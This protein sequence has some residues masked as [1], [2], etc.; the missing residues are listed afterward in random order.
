M[1]P[2]SFSTREVMI[3]QTLIHIPGILLELT[4]EEPDSMKEHLSGHHRF[5]SATM[6]NKAAPTLVFTTG[7]LSGHTLIILD[8]DSECLLARIMI[9]GRHPE[10]EKTLK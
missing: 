6:A 1:S 4:S 7:K 10:L 3:H 5:P 8:P 2:A 9:G